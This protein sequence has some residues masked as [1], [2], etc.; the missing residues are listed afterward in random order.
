[1]SSAVRAI[2]SRSIGLFTVAALGLSPATMAAGS[3][4]EL[5][6]RNLRAWAGEGTARRTGRGSV[7]LPS[8][9]SAALVIRL[10]P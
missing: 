2:A 4:D 6:E 5:T 8:G 10:D 9:G 3:V 1:M 7:E